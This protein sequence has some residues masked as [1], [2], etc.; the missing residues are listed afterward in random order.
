MIKNGNSY[1]NATASRS[2]EHILPQSK[3]SRVP[4]NAEQKGV[5]VHRLGN[6]LLLP[7]DLNSKLSDK[8]PE[9]KAIRYQ[10]TGFLMA[11]EVAQTIDQEGEWGVKQ[12]KKES[13]KLI[14]WICEKWG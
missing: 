3:G 2:I 4:L 7:L 6:L 12:V 10:S 11:A 14:K 1:W 8:E 13:G 9:V 5:F